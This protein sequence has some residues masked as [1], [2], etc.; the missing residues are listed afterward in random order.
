[1]AL[2][3]YARKRNFKKTAEPGAV[4][5]KKKAGSRFVIQKHA[6]SRLHYDFRLEMDGVLKSWAVPKGMP[7]VK[8][9][10]RLAVHVEDHPAGYIQFEGTIPKGQYG[11]GTVM[12]WDFGVFSTAS[13]TPLQDLEAGKL[14]FTLQ[15]K[16]L[17]GDWYLVQ[18]RGSEQWLLI[19]GGEDLK[20]PSAR[21][22]DTSTLSGK[23]MKQLSGSTKVWQPKPRPEAK[24]PREKI[25]AK[26][27]S[28]LE[29]PTASPTPKRHSWPFIEPMK[30]RLATSPPTGDWLYEIKF[31]GFRALAM[32]H[33]GEAALISRN[34]KDLGE[35]FPEIVAALKKLKIRDAV[36]DG[37]IV[38][39][40]NHGVSSFQ[41]LQAFE[42]GEKRPPLYFYAFDLLQIN[43]KD[44]KGKP[45]NERKEL[46][47]TLLEGAPACL[48]FSASLGREAKHLLK[49]A[50][51]LGLE[52]LIGKRADSRYEP[53]SRSGAWIKLKIQ[54]QQEFVIGGYSEPTGT[55]QHFGAL[56]IGFQKQGRLKFCGKVGTGFNARLLK[57]LHSQFRTIA[58]T[59]CPFSNLPE[60]R[61]GRF[62][63]GLTVAEMRR[64]HWLQPR[65][66]AQI[67][68]SEWTRDGK[69]RQPV[70]LG[71]R[72]DKDAADVVREGGQ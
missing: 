50:R 30:A 72:E 4:H 52:G 70:Y 46:L 6:A 65:M 9:E 68:F 55:R 31:D 15:G 60:K 67:R 39:L 22:D 71:L 2:I 12:V 64:C 53:G 51:K 35:K 10:K 1:M 36:L 28:N 5:A 47:E 32:I 62:G 56:L 33:Q 49:E 13:Q 34:E 23:T 59:N 58:Q 24:T 20:P 69:L 57:N 18:L 7:Y 3:E 21:A 41:L 44:L 19:K 43:G 29:K 63:A 17:H 42:L 38:A 11:G 54:K 8:G 66:V 40:D 16:K 61:R 26:A 37:E 27:N 14:H 45:L 48:R 25:K